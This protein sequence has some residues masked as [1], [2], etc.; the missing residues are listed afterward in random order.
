MHSG[1]SRRNII[2]LAGLLICLICSLFLWTGTRSPAEIHFAGYTNIYGITMAS[3]SVSNRC[4]AS[5]YYTIKAEQ[6]RNGKWTNCSGVLQ[7]SSW[8]GPVPPMQD[9]SFNWP[10]DWE[11]GTWRFRAEFTVG[12]TGV[13][14]LLFNVATNLGPASMKRLDFLFRD[15]TFVVLG[16]ELTQ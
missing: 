1:L 15:R 13:R 3:F 6:N 8:K 11:Q 5:V 10:L 16:P 9:F 7:T 4:S 14:K 2:L 12:P